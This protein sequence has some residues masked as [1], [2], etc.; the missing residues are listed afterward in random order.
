M[1]GCSRC[2]LFGNVDNVW[3]LIAAAVHGNIIIERP[4]GYEISG[5]FE[6]KNIFEKT[7]K[8]TTSSKEGGTKPE[9]LLLES[10]SP[11]QQAVLVTILTCLV[12]Y[13]YTD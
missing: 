3:V 7:H 9:V 11:K 10:Q 8:L 5:L 1:I 12:R 2:V 4:P 6:N 13:R